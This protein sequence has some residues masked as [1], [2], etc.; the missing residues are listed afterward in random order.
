MGT[1]TGLTENHRHW[2]KYREIDRILREHGWVA[3]R[4]HPDLRNQLS[5]LQRRR[6]LV[7]LCPGFLVSADTVDDVDLRI[8]VLQ[9]WHP[10]GVLMGAAA[11]RVSFDPDIEVQ[12]IVMATTTKRRAPRGTRLIRWDVPDD[13]VHTTRGMRHT[14]PAL[15]AIDLSRHDNGAAID[16]ALRVGATRLRDLRDALKDTRY[17]LGNP[18]RR[19]M[20]HDSRDLP[21]SQS[22]R[23]THGLLRDAGLT[24]WETNQRVSLPHGRHGFIDISFAEYRIAIEV[25]GYGFHGESESREQFET[26]RF[27]QSSL[28]AQGWV[29]LRFTWRQLVDHPDWVIAMVRQTLA[30]RRR[31]G[32]AL[33]A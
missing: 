13:H 21:W 2:A 29:V 24:G 5:Y 1:L 31:G 32:Y 17:R 15:T 8:R 6:I 30:S 28:V 11:A 3:P 4:D 14:S 25:D 19:A 20:I 22:E 18:V 33:A 27:K 26:D 12:Q 7:P 23:R 16:T 10:D 9:A